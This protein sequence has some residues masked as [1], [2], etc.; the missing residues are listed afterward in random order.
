[1]NCTPV[2]V[3]YTGGIPANN[4]E[5]ALFNSVIA[6]PGP[7]GHRGRGCMGN[8]GFSALQVTLNGDQNNNNTVSLYRSDVSPVG[9][10]GTDA[11]WELVETLAT[12]DFTSSAVARLQFNIEGFS[13][14]ALTFLD[15]TTVQGAFSA[16]I[17]LSFDKSNVASPFAI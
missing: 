11:E 12:V 10:P 13:A 8:Y 2:R 7:N 16:D 1:M 15:G 17:T 4:V 5:T 6:F 3:E 14:F 9:A